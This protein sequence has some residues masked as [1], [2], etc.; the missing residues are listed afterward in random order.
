[1]KAYLP[2]LAAL[3]PA[4]Y[5]DQSLLFRLF[6]EQRA[7]IFVAAGL[8]ERQINVT[9]QSQFKFRSRSHLLLHPSAEHRILV[10]NAGERI[11]RV[12]IDWTEGMGRLVDF[13]I[14]QTHQGL[15]IGTSTVER[16][17]DEADRLGCPLQLTV[18]H[19]SRAQNLYARMGFTVIEETPLQ[20]QMEYLADTKR[21]LSMAT[22]HRSVVSKTP[23]AEGLLGAPAWDE[24]AAGS[25]EGGIRISRGWAKCAVLLF[26]SA[27][28]LHGQGILTVTPSRTVS[29]AAGTGVAGYS[30]DSGHASAAALSDPAAV[31]YD[32]AGNLYVADT[33]N[34]VVRE[35]SINGVITTIAGNGTEGYTGDGAAATAAQLDTPT[36]VAVDAGGNVYIADSHNHCIRKVSGGTII[37]FAGSGISGFSGDGAAA[38][39]ARLSLPSGVAV[40]AI[41]NV[42]IADTNNERIRKVSSG[43]ITSFAGDGEELF[44]GDGAAATAAALDSPTGVAV[45]AI[46]NVYIADR[47]NQRIRKVSNGTITSIAGTSAAGFS[48]DGGFASAA[49]LARP[50]GVSVDSGGNVYIADTGNQRIRE[51]S[52]GAAGASVIATVAGSGAQGFGGDLGLAT[53]A[54]FNSP[55]SVASDASGNLSIA[56]KLN[57]RLRS[58]A[59]P[60]LTFTSEDVG[61]ASAAQSLTL[62]NTGTAFI[63]ISVVTVSAGYATTAGGT[64][65]HLP[66]TLAAGSSCTANV[67]LLSEMTGPSKGSI[68]FSGPGVVPNTIL[69]AGSATSS[70]TTVVLSSNVNPALNGQPIVYTAIITPA[71]I[72]FPT[73]TVAFDAAGVP[74]GAQPLPGG[75]GAAIATTSTLPTGTDSITAV[76]SGDPNFTASTSTAIPQLIEDFSIE[77]TPQP[78]NAAGSA[79]Q[80]VIPGKA[81]TFSF[82][83]T[84]LSG[85]FNF[86]VT[87]SAAGLPPAATVTF[88]PQAA[89]PGT[90]PASFTMTIQTVVDQGALQHEQPI[91]RA[92]TIALLLLPFTL[93]LRRRARGMKWLQ[94]V[95]L[96]AALLLSAAAF[97]SMTGCGTDTGFFAQPQQNY[98]IVITGTAAGSNGFVLQHST[99]VALTVQ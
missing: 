96:A 80:T 6:A 59:L 57:Q 62:S 71:G 24:A 95:S 1:M 69:L 49:I 78:I 16:C 39:S 63:S 18:D 60:A 53:A 37:T 44:A 21:R 72:G 12:L 15:G 75:S 98:N 88:T 29:T 23:P 46:G 92:I 11:G 28:W 56:D 83:L 8:D 47:L 33:N 20:R 51:V 87:L 14:L 19:G 22:A 85:P 9:L 25:S 79:S 26:A 34:H 82:A 90:N 41:G 54:I 68:V 93:R 35:I 45:D 17:L 84:P 94:G 74:F 5:L 32:A 2:Q 66:I 36:G 13:A 27:A 86:P 77:L 61:V 81:A 76:Y 48:G 67:E 4:T 91:G 64:C 30:G 73:G 97:G 55:R 43:T 10:T 70:P 3:Q 50:S 89:T 65:S 99:S 38:T 58:G 7:Q 40:D 52:S 42:Y 31:A